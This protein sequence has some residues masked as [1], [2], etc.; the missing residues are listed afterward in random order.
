MKNKEFVSTTELAEIL[1]VSRVTVF[2]KIKKGEIQAT[3]VGRNFIINR[4]DL[5]NVLDTHILNTD[6]KKQIQKAVK[7]VVSEYG[8]TLKLLGKE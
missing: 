4:K 1:G 6:E 7:K 8:E 5:Y 2:N 3:K